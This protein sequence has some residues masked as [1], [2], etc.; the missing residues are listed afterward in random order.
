[1]K[2]QPMKAGNLKSVKQNGNDSYFEGL[3]GNK[4]SL[5]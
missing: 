1:M 3:D 2:S 5:S 4:T